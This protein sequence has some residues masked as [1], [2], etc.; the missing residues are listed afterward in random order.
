MQAPRD[1]PKSSSARSAEDRRTGTVARV[2][3]RIPFHKVNWPTSSFL[4]GTLLMSLT[5]VPVYIWRFGLDWFQV[6]LFLG[7]FFLTG[8]SITLGIN[9]LFSHLAFQAHW[10]VRLFTLIF[11]A[12]AFENSVLLWACEHRAHHK[13]VDHEDD[14]YNIR[15]G[16]FQAHIGWLLFKLSTPPPFDNVTDLQKDRLVMWQHRYIHWIGATVAFALPAAIGYAWGGGTAALGAFLIAGVAR[17]VLLQHCTFCINSLCHYIGKQT[18]SR[19]CSARDSWLTALVT[20]GEGYHNYH[21]EFP[22]DYRNGVKPWQFDS[23]KWIIWTL[24]KVGLAHKVR[25]VPADTI[26]RAEVAASNDRNNAD[27]H[28]RPHRR[29]YDM[30]RDKG[31]CA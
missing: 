5:L 20:F 17:V 30:G 9:R 22:Y 19:K 31:E 7:M 21:H 14:P 16:L 10:S 24:S 13:H 29:A 18:Y 3:P 11:G 2:F 8:F 6:A 12:A 4:I 26:L 28:N 25:R 23:T 15:E 27:I 1:I